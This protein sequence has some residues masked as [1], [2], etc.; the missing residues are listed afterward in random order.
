[1]GNVLEYVVESL[2]D[3]EV[4]DR[5]METCEYFPNKGEQNEDMSPR[6]DFVFKTE[7]TR[8]CY[9]MMIQ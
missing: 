9:V 1:M 3:M 4:K 6:A 2:G 8:I 7:H 5:M